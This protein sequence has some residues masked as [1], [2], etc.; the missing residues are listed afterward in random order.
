MSTISSVRPGWR[1]QLAVAVVDGAGW[2]VALGTA[3][4]LRFDFDIARVDVSETAQLAGIA[5]GTMLS[6]GLITRSYPGRYPTGSLDDAISL[7]RVTAMGGAA[8]FAVTLA[9][10]TAAI[11]RSVPVIA[12]AL[13]FAI[14]AAA[15]LL[16]RAHKVRRARPHPASATRV[17]VYGSGVHGEALIRLMVSGG[18]GH[19]LPVA[20]LDDDLPRHSRV[21]GVPVQGGIGDLAAVARRTK[22]QVLVVAVP[23]PD[24]ARLRAIVAAASDASLDVKVAHPL[25]DMLR[26]WP[27]FSHLRDLDVVGLLGRKQ[28]HIDTNAIADELA[29]RRVLVTGA[30]G[31]IGSELC[32]QIHRFQPGELLMLDRDESALHAVRL[33]LF[34]KADLDSADII[35]ADIREADELRELFLRRKPDVVFHAAALKHLSMLERFPEQAWKTNVLGTQ[36]VLD[37]ARAAGVRKFVNI[38]TDKAANPTSVLGR[39]KRIGERLVADA[40]TR[41]DGSF[42]SVRF[43]NVLG[44]RGSVLAT[45]TEQLAAGLPLTVTHPEATRFFMTIPEAVELTIQAT[46]IGSSGEALVLDMGEPTR[47]TELATMLMA[48]SGRRSRIVFTGLCDGEKL[49]EELFADDELDHRP[50]HPKISHISVPALDP[51]GLC[52]QAA[53]LGGPEAMTRFASAPASVIPQTQLGLQR[54]GAS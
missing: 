2:A 39:S 12:A 15:R 46:V 13:A 33:S 43:G 35:L 18:A 6:G 31:S 29:G 5:L 24:P 17:I 51:A 11:P 37:A 38:S 4:A 36:N 54:S 53:R 45:F 49:H 32:R 10:V 14:S 23:E 8:T 42:L 7:A 9:D 26:P 47:I 20:V 28:V 44:S 16:V 21:A 41:T 25:H 48:I 50:L 19:H 30:G 34:G 52:A 40:A 3:C 22:A 1:R 27:K